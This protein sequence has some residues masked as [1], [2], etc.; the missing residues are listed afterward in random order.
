MLQ[1]VRQL[2]ALQQLLVDEAGVLLLDV[3]NVELVS[4]SLWFGIVIRKWFKDRS[5]QGVP[6]AS[7]PGLG[8]L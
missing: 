7:G 5:I 1:L 2:D 4:M 8:R 6:S 3:L